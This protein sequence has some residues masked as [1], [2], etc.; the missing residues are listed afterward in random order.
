MRCTIHV[1]LLSSSGVLDLTSTE[2][3]SLGVI[4]A[5]RVTKYFN[6]IVVTLCHLLLNLG[7][8][9]SLVH[10]GLGFGARTGI[11]NELLV[12]IYRHLFLEKGQIH[13]L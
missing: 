11:T 6:T 5:F 8:F 13:P 4:G 9:Y 7:I 12:M 10:S 3:Y 1:I 2:R